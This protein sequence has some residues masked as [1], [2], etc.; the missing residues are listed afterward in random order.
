MH[1]RVRKQLALT[2]HAARART[3]SKQPHVD[4]PAP[5]NE[6]RALLHRMR[7]LQL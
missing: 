3:A 6:A 7:V 5:K 2:D 4:V 1:Y